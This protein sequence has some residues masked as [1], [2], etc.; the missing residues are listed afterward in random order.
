MEKLVKFV[1]K[2]YR[3]VNLWYSLEVANLHSEFG[4]SNRFVVPGIYII[5]LGGKKHD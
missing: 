1:K 5:F 4:N 3:T 2:L